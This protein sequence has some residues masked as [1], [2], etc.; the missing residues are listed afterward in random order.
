MTIRR[1]R[2]SIRVI[3]IGLHWRG[4]RLLAAEVR[5]D[6]GQLKGVRPL[7]GGVEFGETWQAA[8]RRE[9]REELGVEID[10][11]GPTRFMENIFEHHGTIGHEL[12]VF[13][14]IT[15]ATQAFIGKDEIKFSEDGG[16]ECVARWFDLSEL[17]QPNGPQ[18]FP[19]GLKNLIQSE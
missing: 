14:E 12:V 5:D 4:D 17:D 15:F 11:C 16:T 8:L 3:A 13:T 6:H 7:G 9:F 1:P 18:L 10:L 2:Q 19:A